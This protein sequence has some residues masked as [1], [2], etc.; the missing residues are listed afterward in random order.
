MGSAGVHGHEAFSF[1]ECGGFF[2]VYLNFKMS[3]YLEI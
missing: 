1:S 2:C 3:S